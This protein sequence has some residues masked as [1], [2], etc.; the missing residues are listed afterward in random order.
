MK[1][2]IE[3]VL[4]VGLMA[5][6]VACPKPTP[7][8]AAPSMDASDASDVASDVAAA[9]D[10]VGAVDS[11]WCPYSVAAC[12]ALK[13]AGCREGGFVDCAR[14]ICQ[15]NADPTFTHYDLACIAGAADASGVRRCGSDCTP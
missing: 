5:L 6:M 2:D 8:P 15:I 14:V 13:H 11:S 9:S 7:T 12:A 4:V 1:Y 3:A 10:V